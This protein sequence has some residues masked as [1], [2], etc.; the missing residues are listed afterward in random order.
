MKNN[1]NLNYSKEEVKTLYALRLA[2][3]K[4]GIH[5]YLHYGNYGEA[6]VCIAKKDSI[7]KVFECERGRAFDISVYPGCLDACNEVLYRLAPSKSTHIKLL[8]IFNR[9]LKFDF[10]V[11]ELADFKTYFLN[12]KEKLTK[13]EYAEHRKNLE[14]LS[15]RAEEILKQV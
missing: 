13:E 4:F 3:L 8:V 10:T 6:N 9:L 2:T 12:G 5:V 14:R 11:E 15:K 7:W 1:T